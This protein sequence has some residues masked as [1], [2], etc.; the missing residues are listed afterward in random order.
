MKQLIQDGYRLENSIQN[1]ENLRRS[2]DQLAVQTFDLSFEPW[3]GMGYWTDRFLPHVLVKGDKVVAN[4]SVNRMEMQWQGQ[5]RNYLQL[6]TVMTHSDYQGKGLARR[7][8]EQVLEQWTPRCDGI[9]LYA[10]A[11]V[12]EFYPRFGFERG[13]EY[14]QELPWKVPESAQGHSLRKLSMD[15][16]DDVEILA[17]AYEKGN[18][19]SAFSMVNN[20]GLL[21]FYCAQFLKEALYYLPE[22]STVVIGEKE[23]DRFLCY[24]IFGPTGSTLTEVL[25]A[26]VDTL[27]QTVTLGFTAVPQALP[28]GTKTVLID[29]TDDVLFLLKEE[30]NLLT[31]HKMMFPLL[32]HA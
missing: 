9:F 13:R 32:A 21:M 1:N 23:G 19:F 24:D 2:F 18:P 16:Q 17:A 8:L 4:V 25:G 31:Q 10:N 6:G 7:L 28:S 11:E 26:V 15:S 3:H 27:V 5:R 30:E 20:Y 22:L 12:L 29:D 14:Q